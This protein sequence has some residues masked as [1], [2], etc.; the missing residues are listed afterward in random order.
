MGRRLQHLD[1][2]T[3]VGKQVRR[4]Q[5]VV[6]RPDDYRVR[7]FHVTRRLSSRSPYP[8]EFVANK[9]RV[10]LCV[11]GVTEEEPHHDCR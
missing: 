5:P 7:T 8:V 10:V 3:G 11:H 4:H 9:V 6:S 1:T 2:P